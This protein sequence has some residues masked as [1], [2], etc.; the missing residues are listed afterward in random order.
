[1]TTYAFE[2]SACPSVRRGAAHEPQANAKRC[3]DC[4]HTVSSGVVA[5]NALS[6]LIA[7]PVSR[8]TCRVLSMSSCL[9]KVTNNWNTLLYID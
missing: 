6:F 3:R 5:G 4:S 7:E 2:V 9:R 8:L 1:M